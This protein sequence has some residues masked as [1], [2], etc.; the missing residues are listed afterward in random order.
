LKALLFDLDGTI[1]DT[2]EVILVSMQYAHSKVLGAENLP[3]DEELLSLVGIPLRE[4]M[5]HFS[6]D[7][8]N[9]LIEA[10]LDYNEEVQDE[11]LKDFPGTAETLASLREQGYRMTVVTSKRREP[12]IY[13][14]E[15]TGLLEY[16]E[17][18][19]GADDTKEHKPKPSPL[20]HAAEHMGV[21]PEDC[22]YIGDSPY[23]MLAARAANM[24]AI[25][26]L[27]GMFSKE[28]LIDAGA[29]ILISHISELAKTLLAPELFKA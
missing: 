14:L 17:L 26:A 18:V 8:Y 28:S 13:G 21:Y 12:A 19:F 20:L 25:G 10:Y 4:Q 2:R 23:D 22:V 9:E 15:R 3:S 24:Y 27:W 1:L 5:E 6:P 7:K 29:Q 16:F 11:M